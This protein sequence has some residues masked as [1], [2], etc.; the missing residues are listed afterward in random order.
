MLEARNKQRDESEEGLHTSCVDQISIDKCSHQILQKGKC[1]VMFCIVPFWEARIESLRFCDHEPWDIVHVRR[2][3]FSPEHFD[4]S[5]WAWEAQWIAKRLLHSGYHRFVYFFLKR[6]IVVAMTMQSFTTAYNSGFERGSP[7]ALNAQLG[8]S[9]RQKAQDVPAHDVPALLI[10]ARW[11]RN[12]HV[13]PGLHV[14]VI[15]FALL[16]GFLKETFVS[17]GW[18]RWWLAR[19]D[20]GTVRYNE[21]ESVESNLYDSVRYSVEGLDSHTQF[22][23]QKVFAQRLFV[24]PV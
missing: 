9:L 15:F 5:Q 21:S 6:V 8:C 2:C 4:F 14:L 1:F 13:H 17:F 12:A 18:L 24:A 11:E 7:A 19:F 16:K 20:S 3:F 23:R 22:K 10:W